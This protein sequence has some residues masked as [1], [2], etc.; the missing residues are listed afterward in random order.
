MVRSSIFSAALRAAANGFY[1]IA[2]GPAQQLFIQTKAAKKHPP[3]MEPPIFTGVSWALGDGETL[4]GLVNCFDPAV[5]RI[6]VLFYLL[7]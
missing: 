4:R 5:Y 3:P 1:L 6:Q 7:Q 2:Q